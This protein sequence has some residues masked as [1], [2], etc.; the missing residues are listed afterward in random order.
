MDGSIESVPQ[1]QPGLPKAK[2]FPI[3]ST[4]VLL[5]LVH[6]VALAGVSLL[7]LVVTLLACFL[8][9]RR[10]TKVDPLEALRTE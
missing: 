2:R 1:A 9:A 10:A 6:L 3:R 7:L 5:V 4:M 8:P